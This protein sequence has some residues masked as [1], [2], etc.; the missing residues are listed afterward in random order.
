M[1]VIAMRLGQ[2]AQGHGTLGIGLIAC[3]DRLPDLDALAEALGTAF[4][5]LATAAGC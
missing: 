3:P 2:V 4:D 5:E 1:K